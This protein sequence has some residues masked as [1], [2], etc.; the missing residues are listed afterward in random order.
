M[1]IEPKDDIKIILSPDGNQAVFWSD[2]VIT[3][4]D[5]MEKNCFSFRP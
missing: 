3:I 4:Y 2:S 5:I 1:N